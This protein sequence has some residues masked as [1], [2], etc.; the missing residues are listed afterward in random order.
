MW[1]KWLMPGNDSVRASYDFAGAQPAWKSW[2]FPGAIAVA[3]II[4]AGFFWPAP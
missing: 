1:L 2:W 3:A 4:I